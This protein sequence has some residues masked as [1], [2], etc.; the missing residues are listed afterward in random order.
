V[1]P[2]AAHEPAAVEGANRR[3][4]LDEGPQAAHPRRHL[5]RADRA[6]CAAL[7]IQFGLDVVAGIEQADLQAAQLVTPAAAAATVATGAVA[8]V[9]R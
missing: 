5:H 3:P 9:T 8:M 2:G 7:Q 6:E 1:I 4:G